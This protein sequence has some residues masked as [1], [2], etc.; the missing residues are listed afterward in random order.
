MLTTNQLIQLKKGF[1]R[2]ETSEFEYKGK[3]FYEGVDQEFQYHMLWEDFEEICTI[4]TSNPIHKKLISQ[5]VQLAKP[6]Y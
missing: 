2:F 4:Q 1:E 6:H 3:D 5:I